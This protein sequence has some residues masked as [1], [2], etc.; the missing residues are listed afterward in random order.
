M[1]K[2]KGEVKGHLLGLNLL[3]RTIPR[4]SNPQSPWTE[5]SAYG[6]SV[7]LGAFEFVGGHPPNSTP[8]PPQTSVALWLQ[9][10]QCTA[11]R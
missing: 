5:S 1:D 11:G 7:F 6:A 3:A 4:N 8:V 9:T 10:T 2:K